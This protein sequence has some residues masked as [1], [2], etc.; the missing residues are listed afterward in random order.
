M[1]TTGVMRFRQTLQDCRKDRY[2]DVRHGI[3][4]G[5]NLIVQSIDSFC[6]EWLE[7]KKSTGTTRGTVKRNNSS[8]AEKRTANARK[9]ERENDRLPPRLFPFEGVH[10]EF[11][12]FFCK[13]CATLTN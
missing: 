11:A 1:V 4:I 3:T 2:E 7:T 5:E 12:L 10:F 6:G 13:L 8:F 9:I